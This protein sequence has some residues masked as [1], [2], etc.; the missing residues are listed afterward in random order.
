MSLTIQIRG[1]LKLEYEIWQQRGHGD[2][3]KSVVT[4]TLGWWWS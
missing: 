1:G 4:K 2:L 3:N